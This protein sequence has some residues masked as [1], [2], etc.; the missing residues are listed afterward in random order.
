MLK[1]KILG[2]ILSS[3]LLLGVFPSL[4][5]AATNNNVTEK[6]NGLVVT[7][8]STGG[9]VPFLINVKV[10]MTIKVKQPGKYIT[11]ESLYGNIPG[12]KQ[13]PFKQTLKVNSIKY[14]KNGSYLTTHSLPNQ[15]DL[16]SSPKDIA[17]IRD[18]TLNSNF[19][20]NA[21]HKAVGGIQWNGSTKVFPMTFEATATDSEVK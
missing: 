5:S 18:K 2:I 20:D 3:V 1:K 17:V 7:Y 14:Y 16:L 9:A 8:V 19:A 13:F 4:T 6:N 11:Y 21:T 12:G 10:I 15:P